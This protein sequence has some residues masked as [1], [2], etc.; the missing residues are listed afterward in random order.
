[1]SDTG[2][3][4]GAENNNN[5]RNISGTTGKFWIRPED[6]TVALYQC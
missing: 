2:L 1:M 4:P 6:Y 3:D 5:I